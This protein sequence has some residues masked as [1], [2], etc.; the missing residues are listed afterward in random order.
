M[1][2][3][4]F[5]TLHSCVIDCAGTKP[6]SLPEAQKDRDGS[7][8]EMRMSSESASKSGLVNIRQ[9]APSTL[10]THACHRGIYAQ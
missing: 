9:T 1:T 7:V 8:E 5:C 6:V 3:V 4:Q 10:P 2:N